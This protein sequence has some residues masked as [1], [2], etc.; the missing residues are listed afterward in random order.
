MKKLYLSLLYSAIV[1]T[2]LAQSAFSQDDIPPMRRLHHDNID[3]SQLQLIKV[4]GGNGKVFM[5]TNDEGLNLQLTQNIISKIDKLQQKVEKDSSFTENDKYIWLRSINDMLTDFTNACK[6]KVVKGTWVVDYINAYKQA[7]QLQ[8]KNL[9]ITSVVQQNEL[10]IGNILLQNFA[11]K[12]NAGLKDCK[13]IL[14]YKQYKR[15]PERA[16]NIINEHPDI[17][18]QIVL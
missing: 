9:P 16:F 1:F 5:A 12:Q 4:Y 7:M 3:K 15:N 6:Y 8:V 18:L 10:E 2:S 11:F 17:F 13:D 14:V